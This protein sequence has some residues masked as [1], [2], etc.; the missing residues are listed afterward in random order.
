MLITKHFVLLHFPRTGG[1]FFRRMCQEHL[2]ADWELHELPAT[3]AYHSAIPEE[4]VGLPAICFIRNPW[5]WYVS[6]YEFT[7]RYMLSEGRGEQPMPATN[8]WNT[9]FDAGRRDFR[10][11]VVTA[12]TRAEGDRPWELA[13]RE[14]DVDLCTGMFWLMAGHA[15]APPPEDSPLAPLFPPGREVQTGKYERF[16]EDFTAF[17]ER[18]AIPAPDAFMDAIRNEPPRHASVRRP[19]REYYDDE[20]RDLVGTK[21]RYLIERYGYAF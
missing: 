12:C 15:P 2:P 3:H 20:L 4:S 1:I 18:N 16:R 11:T 14:W 21:A 19:Y 13:M 6:W 5:D 10:E 9:L 8:P 7:T 17:V